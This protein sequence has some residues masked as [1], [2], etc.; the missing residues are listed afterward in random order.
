ME[1]QLLYPLHEE[2]DR[3]QRHCKL[4]VHVGTA[5]LGKEEPS[6]DAMSLMFQHWQRSCGQVA[7]DKS[8]IEFDASCVVPASGNCLV[9]LRNQSG[10][11]LSR[12]F[13]EGLLMS[14]ESPDGPFELNCPHYYVQAASA[15]RED[16]A[17]AI[18]SPVNCMVQVSYGMPRAIARVVATINNF[19][20]EHGNVAS[21]ADRPFECD[22][23]RVEARGRVVDFT[24]RKDRQ[25]LRQMLDVGLLHST[26]LSTFSFDAWDGA[27][28]DELARFADNVASL[29]SV[30]ARQHTGIPVLAFVDDQGRV[31]RRRLGNAIESEF[32][33]DYILRHMQLDNGFPRL[34]RQ[35]FDEHVRMEESDLWK[36]MPSYCAG[37]DDP[38]Y[39][40]QKLATLMAAV[41]ILLRNSLIEAGHYTPAEAERTMLPKL[42]G[43][44]RQFLGWQIPRHYTAKERHRFLRNASAH[45]A[46]LPGDV[47]HVRNDFD[48]WRLFL[49]RRYLLRLGFDGPVAS[50]HQ[51]WAAQSRVSDFSE[52]YNS[53]DA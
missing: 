16:P 11:R 34:F 23:L 19:D 13:G 39:L 36:R 25:R 29:C 33:S 51:G 31:V 43:A 17:W 24:P 40:E 8:E 49:M 41:E 28:V 35:C 5:R 26:A 37:I 12:N 42:I 9:F 53:Y 18:V 27:S 38:P 21:N 2:A 45:G 47:A 3:I 6:T 1:K 46:P 32:R 50:P 22:I 48:K 52:D 10:L 44:A 14:G 15:F 30:V 7:I 4:A 20:F